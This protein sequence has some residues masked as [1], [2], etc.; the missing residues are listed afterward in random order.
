MEPSGEVASVRSSCLSSYVVEEPPASEE[1]FLEAMGLAPVKDAPFG[2]LSMS[3]RC[4]SLYCD[5]E[6]RNRFAGSPNYCSS[7][8]SSLSCAKEVSVSSNQGHQLISPGATESISTNPTIHMHDPDNGDS[9]IDILSYLVPLSEDVNSCEGNCLES[10]NDFSI[11]C[12]VSNNFSI[13]E[14]DMDH[15]TNSVM[16]HDNEY[17][18]FGQNQSACNP[19]SSNTFSIT[20]PSQTTNGM[21]ITG[22]QCFF[23]LAGSFRMGSR[24]LESATAKILPNWLN[25]LVLS[26]NSVRMVEPVLSN[27]ARLFGNLIMQ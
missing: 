13:S 4:E 6:A 12:S 17:Q 15:S 22:S 21:Q 18:P 1:G 27:E 2:D 3:G 7:S 25:D 19:T 24:L 9:T 11:G 23:D 5:Q 26:P 16:F 14:V 10:H 20:I 8:L